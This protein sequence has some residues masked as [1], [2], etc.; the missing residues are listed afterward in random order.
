MHCENLPDLALNIVPMSNSGKSYVFLPRN[1]L[2]DLF[3]SFGMPLPTVFDGYNA[4]NTLDFNDTIP[5]GAD[6][7]SWAIGRT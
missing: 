4:S 3:G 2:S 5:D 1:L 6:P 7:S